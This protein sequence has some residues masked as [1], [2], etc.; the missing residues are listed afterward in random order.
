MW[1][2][3]IKLAGEKSRFKILLLK[4][5][6]VPDLDSRHLNFLKLKKW[7]KPLIGTGMCALSSLIFAF[8][9]VLV[10]E[11]SHVNFFMVGCVRFYVMAMMSSPVTMQRI[12]IESPFPH[13]K[14]WLLFWRSII[15]ATNLMTN[16]YGIQVCIHMYIR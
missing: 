15:G 1:S 10:K 12:H 6:G 11:L 3:F 5:M 2:K 14:R 4:S 13:G 8:A 9:H 16:Y 7:A